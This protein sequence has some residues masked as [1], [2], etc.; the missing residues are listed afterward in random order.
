MPF[1]ATVASDVFQH[2]LDECFGKIEQ[3]IIVPD[4]NLIVGYKPNYSDISKP[5][6]PC[7]RQPGS[8]M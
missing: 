8:V 1:G 5:S 7:C 3:V 2:K 4:D 6:Q